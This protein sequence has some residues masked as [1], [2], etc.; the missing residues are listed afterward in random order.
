MHAETPCG[1][2]VLFVDDKLEID[3]CGFHGAGPVAISAIRDLV[4]PKKMLV[5]SEDDMK[6]QCP[7]SYCEAPPGQKCI[8]DGKNK[9]QTHTNFRHFERMD[10]YKEKTARDRAEKI[11]VIAT[12]K[13]QQKV[14]ERSIDPN[15]DYDPPMD[16]DTQYR[17]P[18]VLMNKVVALP[19]CGCTIVGHGHLQSPVKIVFCD[20]HAGMLPPGRVEM[21]NLLRE[22]T[23]N[24]TLLEAWNWCQAKAE[25]VRIEGIGDL[26]GALGEAAAHGFKTAGDHF[27]QLHVQKTGEML[28]ST[29][30]TIMT[31]ELA[32]LA[33][34]TLKMVKALKNVRPNDA[35]LIEVLSLVEEQATSVLER[36]TDAE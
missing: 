28:L 20:L 26:H 29:A 7:V 21:I 19:G 35:A 3:Y 9:P 5:K 12:D 15:A 27:R 33:N 23:R 31:V 32:L 14:A 13:I 25:L 1:C 34:N 10:A 6:I 24:Q 16:V 8:I 18:H 2:R 36:W 17:W 22:K 30:V 4:Y 11:M